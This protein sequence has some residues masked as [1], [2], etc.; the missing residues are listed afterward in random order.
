MKSFAD[1]ISKSLYFNYL[2]FSTMMVLIIFIFTYGI[3]RQNVQNN[4]NILFKN[5]EDFINNYYVD[6][7][8]E[9]F[10]Y[11]TGEIND[12]DKIDFIYNLNNLDFIKEPENKS[13]FNFS[14]KDISKGIFVN[15]SNQ[16]YLINWQYFDTKRYIYGVSLKKLNE[17]INSESHF[18]DYIPV[19]KYEDKYI[20]PDNVVFKYNLENILD[21]HP[22]SIFLDNISYEVLYKN[23]RGIDFFILYNSSVLNELKNTLLIIGLIFLV[24][25]FLI[26]KTNIQYIKSQIT[27][28]I[29][30]IVTGIKNIKNHKSKEIIYSED[31]EFKLIKNEFNSLYKNLYK[32]IEEL[33]NSEKNLKKS[34][35]FKSNIL[36]ILSHE[37]RT[38]IHSIMGFSEILQMKIKDPED[39]ESLKTIKKSSQ[40][41]LNKFDR[42]FERSKIESESDEIKLKLSRFN[43][44]DI[45]FEVSSKY[46]S[47]CRKKGITLEID[48]KNVNDFEDVLLDYNKI[49]RIME[50]VL[51]NSYKFTDEGKII[52]SLEDDRDEIEIKIR[53]TG[54]GIKTENVD[55]LYDSFF[56]T[57]NYL[58]RKK[59]GLG[60]GLS[61]VK[62][63]V[64]MMGGKIYI[65]NLD[66]GTSVKIIFQ[67]GIT[68]EKINNSSPLSDLKKLFNKKSREEVSNILGKINTYFDKIVE[69][70][71]ENELYQNIL[72]LQSIFNSNKLEQSNIVN[73]EIMNLLKERD[74][75]EILEFYKE[76]RK[77]YENTYYSI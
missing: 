41:I 52:I 45:I 69:S 16:L 61:I 60:I 7:T 31:D 74:F 34:S 35:E 38:P 36:K 18:G 44:L 3:I 77:T 42:L 25:G 62:N 26:S 47:L 55:L 22:D 30:S 75:V 20:I 33:E 64:Q 32:S 59:D 2:I 6:M 48:E 70:T 17:I 63:Y 40:E 73:T 12:L 43:L 28:P 68:K 5:K 39:R 57:E 51:D 21:E 37:I 14:Y 1:K 24:L 27:A 72:E 50:E 19:M 23:I 10:S 11:M 58:N 15:D 29:S 46:E 56:Q 4:L 53:D 8:E 49:K 13:N 54:I 66:E 76:F 67:K 9:F 65:H 71:T